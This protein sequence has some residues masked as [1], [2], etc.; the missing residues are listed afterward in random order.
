M[1]PAVIAA[2]VGVAGSLQLY[3]HFAGE[4]PV[5][6]AAY[7]WRLRRMDLRRLDRAAS[8]AANRADLIVS[9]TTLPSRIDRTT[10]TIKSLLNQTRAPCEIRMHVPHTSRREQRPYA[11]PDWLASLESVR[12]VRCD[13]YGPATKAIPAL[14]TLHTHQRILVVDDDR[15]YQPWLVAQMAALADAH[16]DYAIAGSGWDAPADLVDRP[17]RLV[18]TLLARAPAPIKCTRVSGIRDVDVMQGLSGYVVRPEFFDLD[19]LADYR[20]APPAAFYVDD[21]WISAQCRARKVVA[22]GRRTNF[23]SLA[24]ARFFKRSS[25]ALVN[26]GDGTPESR[27]NTIMLNYFRDRWRCRQTLNT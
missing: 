5:L 16:P 7:D 9:L 2:G 4:H 20:T 11:V 19:G 25:V 26:R 18:D 10:L 6:D 22:E 1:I 12:V 14:R 24:D 15:V 21:V 3:A 23:P 27:N 13:D 8:A 17:T